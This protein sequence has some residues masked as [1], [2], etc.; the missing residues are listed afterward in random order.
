MSSR[1]S[2]RRGGVG[3]VEL[4]PRPLGRH[5]RRDLHP[6]LLRQAGKAVTQRNQRDDVT[7]D[8]AGGE[9]SLWRRSSCAKQAKQ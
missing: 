9:A 4:W 5:L 2:R 1:S 3:P 7:V 8:W 6:L